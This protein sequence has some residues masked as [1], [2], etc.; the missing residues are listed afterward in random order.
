[1]LVMRLD[2]TGV[3]DTTFG[4]NGVVTHDGAAGGT[5]EQEYG[6][7]IALDSNGKIVVAGTSSDASSG[8]DMAIWRLNSDGS[9]DTGF[10]SDGVVTHAI[11]TGS[12]RGY[13]L[14]IDS[15]DRIIVVG[16]TENTSRDLAVWR[17]NSDGSL[18]T[19]FN[20]S[21]YFVQDG[22]AGGSGEERADAVTID[23]S[24]KIVV[25]GFSTNVNNRK[26]LVVWRFN[27]DGTLD[28]SFDSDGMAVVVDTVST[29]SEDEAK[30][31]LIDSDGKI[32]VVGSSDDGS[33]LRP[34]IWRFNDD[35]SLDTTFNTTGHVSDTTSV[36]SALDLV[37]DSSGNIMVS[38]YVDDGSS[39]NMAIWRFTAAGAL[40]TEFDSDGI[41]THDAAAGFSGTDGGFA[42]AIDTSSRLVI[43]GVSNNGTNTD[44]AVWRTE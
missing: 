4:T 11:G 31:V 37:L 25:A 10:D 9:M 32:I 22:A 7:A 23:A 3:L 21:G 44:F 41:Y 16:R 42:I 8:L 29:D 20:G 36:G 12:D 13:G 30:E 14:A 40:D 1:M 26:D 38:G 5:D 2:D 24:G 6:E 15:T 34:T 17:F 35:G 43:A 28:T 18:D 33:M 27:T 19:T 39:F